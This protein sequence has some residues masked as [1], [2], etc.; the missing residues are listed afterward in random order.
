[1]I[2]EPVIPVAALYECRDVAARAQ[3]TVPLVAALRIALLVAR[4][5]SSLCDL[6]LTL[7][8]SLK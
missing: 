5:A 4:V 3:A 8:F 7:A 6:K 2:R 1:L